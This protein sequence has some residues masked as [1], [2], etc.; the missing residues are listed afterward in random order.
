[1]ILG[2]RGGDEGGDNAPVA[3][4][5]IREYVAHEV[6]AATLSTRVKHL[7]DDGLDAQRR[8]LTKIELS[9]EDRLLVARLTCR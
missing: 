8:A 2:E 7:G 5:G 6:H 3:L 4:A 1:M 9:R